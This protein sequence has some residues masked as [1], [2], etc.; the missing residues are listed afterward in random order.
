MERREMEPKDL[1]DALDVRQGTLSDWMRD[2]RGLPEGPTLIKFAKALGAT[3]EEL[4]EGVDPDYDEVRGRA[5]R[6]QFAKLGIRS[7]AA[8]IDAGVAPTENEMSEGTI[9]LLARDADPIDDDVSNYIRNDIPIIQE[10]EASPNGLTWDAGDPK[11]SEVE[12]L[13]RPYDF[14]EKGAYAVVLRGDSMEPILK[15]GMRLI[16][17]VTQPVADGDIAYVQM[18]NRERLVK[19]ATR[20]TDGWLLTSANPA[21]PPRQVHVSEIEHIHKVAWVRFLK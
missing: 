15:R 17:S 21:H 1:A 7:A 16:M 5:V 2:R 6:D 4:L 3:V 10:G 13:S 11:T 8:L 14:R 20:V 12:R 18:K 9:D 19:I